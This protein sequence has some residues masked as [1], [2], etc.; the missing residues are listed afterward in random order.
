MRVFMQP[1][2]KVPPWYL[3]VVQC[4]DGTLYTGVTLDTDRRI[5]EHN[6]SRRGAKYTR[7]RRP[8]K[9]VYK[10]R[11]DNQAEALQAEYQFKKLLRGQKLQIIKNSS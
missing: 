5:F 4:N 10:R 11:Y 6:T 1:Q 2:L 8:V 9:L 7:A 3:Y